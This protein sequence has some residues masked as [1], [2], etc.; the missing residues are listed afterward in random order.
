MCTL[1]N[2]TKVHLITTTALINEGLFNINF[3][4]LA[5]RKLRLIGRKT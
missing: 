5:Q 2:E 3:M 4:F 1:F